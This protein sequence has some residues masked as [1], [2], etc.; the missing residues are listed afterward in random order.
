M[1]G[2]RRFAAAT[3]AGAL[4]AGNGVSQNASKQITQISGT[5][6]T[7]TSNGNTTAN[8]V[9]L[10]SNGLKA[11]NN[12]GT[13]TVSIN[14][15]GSATF[16]GTVSASTISGSTFSSSNNLFRVDG[17][18]NTFTNNIYATGT[19]G[20]F[21]LQIR[22]DS[23]VTGSTSG[24]IWIISAKEKETKIGNKEGSLNIRWREAAGTVPA[25]V[26]LEPA[27]LDGSTWRQTRHFEINMASG[28]AFYINSD[29]VLRGSGLDGTPSPSNNFFSDSPVSVGTSEGWQARW[30]STS[31]KGDYAIGRATSTIK[32][33]ENIFSVSGDQALQILNK[34]NLKQFTYKKNQYDDEKS[35]KIKQLNIDYGFIA[36]EVSENIPSLAVYDF[37]ELGKQKIRSEDFTYNDLNNPEYVEPAQW[38]NGA[39]LALLVGAVQNLN[40]RVESLEAQLAAR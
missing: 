34:L 3:G 37:T 32:N 14:S 24:A 39:V 26:V 27:W 18:G 6:V 21:G 20:N 17:D 25:A 13:P 40:E 29:I 11:Y 8:R 2:D 23:P 15:D 4:Q 5:G 38:K 7:I 9:Q 30:I 12:V 19:S 35:Y 16:T 10:D 28:Y 1:Y 33:K 22:A 31:S 36:E